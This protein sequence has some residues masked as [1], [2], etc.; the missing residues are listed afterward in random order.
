M[1]EMR[2]YGS[3]PFN[4]VVVHG[5]PGARGEMAP[6]AKELSRYVGVLEPM[7]LSMTIDGEVEELKGTIDEHGPSPVILIGH[8]WGAW[9]SFI[10]AAKYPGSVRKLIMISSGPFEDEYARSMIKTR[11]ERMDRSDTSRVKQLLKTLK[12]P[13]T[14][15]M[16]PIMKELGDIF[17]R[18]D[19]YDKIM[20]DDVPIEHLDTVYRNVW[21]EADK[22]RHSGE[23]LRFGD[24]IKCPVVAIHG[25]YDPHPVK[26]VE[27]PLSRVLSDFRMIV[28]KDCG[29]T[30]WAERRAREEF[31]KLLEQEI[32][33]P[34]NP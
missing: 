8:S 23:L 31:Y 34:N 19:F 24:L 22:L 26:G 15:D 32:G 7:Q 9:L 11:L 2:T 28:L 10:V 29:H 5:G 33:I 21:D 17:S 1:E 25:D 4:V 12:D 20:D 16:Q 30:P 6:V 27:V 14:N 13:G 18:T 3:A